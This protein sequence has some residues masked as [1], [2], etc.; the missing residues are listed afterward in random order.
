MITFED[1]PVSDFDVAADAGTIVYVF[2]DASSDNTQRTLVALDGGGR[3]ELF[4][5]EVSAP[6]ISP[7]GQTLVA[8]L[9]NPEPGLIV[10]QDASPPGVWSFPLSGGRPSLVQSDDS[11][12][13]QE[14]P[15]GTAWTYTPIGYDRGGQRLLL[16]AYNLGG[17]SIPGGELVIMSRS[18]TA[19]VRTSTC[20]EGAA[21]SVDGSAVTIVGGAPGPDLRYGLYRIDATAGD[22]KPIIEQLEG[23]V[24]LVMGARQL[25]DGQIYAF[26]QEVKT[27]DFNW[28][29]PFTAQM[30]R[31]ADGKI[32]PLR[33]DS[34]KQEE[35]IWRDDASGALITTRDRMTGDG[36]RPQLLWLDSSGGP[37]VET[38]A[39]GTMPRWADSV[40]PLYEGDCTLLPAIAWQSA[41]KRVFSAGALDLQRRL[42]ANGQDVGSP[43]G[44]FGDQTRAAL[45]AFQKSKGIP[46]N[47]VLDCATWQALLGR[48]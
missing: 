28:D 19:P 32:T 27:D 30:V 7:D 8:R 33:Q 34:Y 25:L 16:W 44:F 22:E 13:G 36:S 46:P 48:P 6:R 10:G 29:Y 31:V 45:H 26:Y 3:R 39:F 21:W 47:D 1:S 2:G 12:E 35:A 9:D 11:L 18:G 4:V 24:P 14:P 37:A 5:G 43:D 17:P 20:C 40:R 23:G 15:D 41:A 38:E 42:H